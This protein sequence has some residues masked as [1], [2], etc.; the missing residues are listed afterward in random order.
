MRERLSEGERAG[1]G[2]E[3]SDDFVPKPPELEVAT[4]GRRHWID[5]LKNMMGPYD[6]LAEVRADKKGVEAFYREVV[7]G[8]RAEEFMDGS[9]IP[10]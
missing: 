6:T 5:G 8:S 10:G 1:V 3:A 2:V 7:F 4:I 9:K